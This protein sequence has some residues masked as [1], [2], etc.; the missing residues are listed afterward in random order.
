MDIV[1]FMS[2]GSRLQRLVVHEIGEKAS[3]SKTHASAR[4]ISKD[5]F[6]SA[7]PHS[8]GRTASNVASCMVTYLPGL[9][10]LCHMPIPQAAGFKLEVVIVR[11]IAEWVVALIWV[12][13]NHV[14]KWNAVCLVFGKRCKW[15]SLCSNICRRGMRQGKNR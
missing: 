9:Q 5:S 4:K 10:P 2:C 1:T 7:R 13:W 11:R 15:R 12:S 8:D 3:K 14:K 6:V